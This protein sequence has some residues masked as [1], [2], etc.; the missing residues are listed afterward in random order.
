MTP[1]VLETLQEIGKQLDR[2]IY[3]SV[4]NGGFVMPCAADVP[5]TKGRGKTDERQRSRRSKTGSRD[6]TTGRQ[7]PTGET[8][9]VICTELQSQYETELDAVYEAY[10]KT[11]VWQQSDG[12]L[13]LTESALI[14]DL[15]R[16]AHFLVAIPY[17]KQSMAKGWGFWGVSAVGAEWIG[18]RH[19]NFP[20]GSIC[21]FEPSDG[22]WKIGYPL[23]QLLDLYSLWALR[24]LHMK[25]LGRWP[26]YQ[27]VRSRYERI[28]EL[29]PDE[30]C[31]CEHSD[32]LYGECCQKGDLAENTVAG[33]IAFNKKHH[34]WH[35][36]PPTIVTDFVITRSNP[37][38][39]NDVVFIPSGG[40]NEP[41]CF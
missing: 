12:L 7:G 30:Y 2:N 40:Y 15:D 36:K 1:T 24:H 18:P 37:P 9:S 22:T 17:S 20:D 31:G 26:G 21:A 16:T 25:A 27:A 28:L 34:N 5:E 35:R 38:N 14:K 6:G 33:A 29:R 32:R 8:P 3:P 19:T 11:R 10:P 4:H 41:Q 13:L 23:V 39:I